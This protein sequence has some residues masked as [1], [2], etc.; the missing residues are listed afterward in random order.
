MDELRILRRALKQLEGFYLDLSKSKSIEPPTWKQDIHQFRH[1]RLNDCLLI[2]LKGV[3]SV[4]LLNASMTLFRTGHAQEIGILCRCLDETF[5][6]M[7]LFIR[8]LGEDGR[9]TRD[10]ERA[11]TEF[12]QEQFADPVSPLGTTIKRDRVRRAKVRTAIAGLPENTV[13]PHDHSTVLGTID[14]AMSGYVH[15]AY[16]HIMELYGGSP[17]RF[18]MTGMAGTPRIIEALRQI[19]IYVD[20]AVLLAWYASKRL[21]EEEVATRIVRLRKE[22]EARYPM[23]NGDPTEAIRKM[24][25][26]AK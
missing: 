22:M 25:A 20:R 4:S 24:K 15:G 2:F 17:P 18:H 9:P 14:D 6:D 10:Q 11:L 1:E 19:V 12:F 7:L 21:G 3:R 23:L 13:N 5:E 8:N 26:R 16:P